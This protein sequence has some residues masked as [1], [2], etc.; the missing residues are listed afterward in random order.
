MELLRLNEIN[1]NNINHPF[2]SEHKELL[3]NY[4]VEIIDLIGTDEE[5]Q[6]SKY[7]LS[8]AIALYIAVG[9]KLKSFNLD[10]IRRGHLN[11]PTDLNS[12]INRL[13]EYMIINF[14]DSIETFVWK[15][16]N[17]F[18]KEIEDEFNGDY[19]MNVIVL[20]VDPTI[21]LLLLLMFVPFILNVQSSLKKIYT[22]LCELR[23]E[24]IKKWLEDCN[25][26]FDMIKL[27]IKRIHEL[28]H[29]QSFEIIQILEE[30]GNKKHK[31]EIK[32]NLNMKK[33]Q[34]R[35]LLQKKLN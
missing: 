19:V 32:K 34:M 15:S 10:D 23:S 7:T 22:H 5:P 31:K 3:L 27:S 28:Y 9:T 30:E 8:T 14:R 17:Y 26:S 33:N 11:A 12:T 16:Y 1:M 2:S 25:N 20:T 18:P 29:N 4:N 6:I 21:S 13:M 24:E 35:D